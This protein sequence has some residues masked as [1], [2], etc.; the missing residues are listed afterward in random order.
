MNAAVELTLERLRDAYQE[1]QIA[2]IPDDKDYLDPTFLA[3]NMEKW[4]LMPQKIKDVS[5][6]GQ[7]EVA[8]YWE[9]YFMLCV[10]PRYNYP[11][12]ASVFSF[13]QQFTEEQY[14]KLS[15][16]PYIRSKVLIGE[17]LLQGKLEEQRE[18]W[19]QFIEQQH[20]IECDGAIYIDIA[21]LMRD[22]CCHW[23]GHWVFDNVVLNRYLGDEIDYNSYIASHFYSEESLKRFLKFQQQMKSIGMNREKIWTLFSPSGERIWKVVAIFSWNGNTE[24]LL[25]ESKDEFLELLA[26]G[27]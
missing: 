11:S 4:D 14:S 16:T 17:H 2:K 23:S 25:L 12:L 1:A 15:Y 3:T 21:D 26:C 19:R 20:C 9:Q 5:Q 7:I 27:S 18:I 24:W 13:Y 8:V 6:Y 22:T 10:Y